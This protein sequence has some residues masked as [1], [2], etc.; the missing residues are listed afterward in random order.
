M[1]TTATKYDLRGWREIAECLGVSETTAKKWAKH[2]G[3]PVSKPL[4]R[5]G[6][7]SSKERLAEWMKKIEKNA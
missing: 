2:C 4:L 7:Y 3:L 1:S 6:V 5:G